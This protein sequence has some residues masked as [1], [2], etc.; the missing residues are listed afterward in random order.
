MLE[1]ALAWLYSIQFLLESNKGGVFT[2][3]YF[4]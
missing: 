2:R 4:N 1:M 3:P